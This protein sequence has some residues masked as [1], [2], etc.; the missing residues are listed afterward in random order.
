M[1]AIFRFSQTSLVCV[2]C[3]WN[4]L[5]TGGTMAACIEPYGTDDMCS[6]TFWH[7][8]SYLWTTN[9]NWLA[10]MNIIYPWSDKISPECS[11]NFHSFSLYMS[12]IVMRLIVFT[13]SLDAI[14][15]TFIVYKPGH[16]RAEWH[17]F[18]L[19]AFHEITYHI[20]LLHV[21]Q[22]CCLC[23]CKKRLGGVVVSVPVTWKQS[24]EI[25]SVCS[26]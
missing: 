12:F 6:R 10:K 23:F 18:I 14:N 26:K 1:G 17:H 8:F 4:S 25:K 24:N 7:H 15:I 9:D 16:G 19:L 22:F 2:S 20:L 3:L 13:P 11:Y 5:M 21:E